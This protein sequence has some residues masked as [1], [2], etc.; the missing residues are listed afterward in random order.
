[1]PATLLWLERQEP[2]NPQVRNQ[3]LPAQASVSTLRRPL[4]G[5]SMLRPC[6]ARLLN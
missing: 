3:T 2:L 6:L 4:W 1:M 5:R